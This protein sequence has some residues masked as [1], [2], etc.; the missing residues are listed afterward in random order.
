MVALQSEA[1]PKRD[2]LAAVEGIFIRGRSLRFADFRESRLYAADAQRAD[3]RGASLAQS[4]LPTER[5]GDVGRG[6]DRRADCRARTALSGWRGQ[7]SDGSLP[8][9]NPAP[10]PYRGFRFPREVIQHA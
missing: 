1:T 4:K 5:R 10:N 6:A 8:G 3:L 9:M 2:L 7:P